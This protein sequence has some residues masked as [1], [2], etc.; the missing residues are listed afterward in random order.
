[1][2]GNFGLRSP[3]LMSVLSGRSLRQN[4]CASTFHWLTLDSVGEASDVWFIL[5][6]S[7]AH[8]MDDRLSATPTESPSKF[9]TAPELLSF[10][11]PV[12]R[13]VQSVGDLLIIPPRWYVFDGQIARDPHRVAVLHRI[14]GKDRLLLFHGHVCQS[15]A[16]VWH[17]IM[18][19]QCTEG[20]IA[21]QH[22][23]LR[24]LT[25]HKVVPSGGVQRSGDDLYHNEVPRIGGQ[26]IALRFPAGIL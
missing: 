9:M 17:Y 20:T 15:T 11:F 19:Y 4:H 25:A 16:W 8:Q 10:P 6:A 22:A 3:R 14:S 1:M 12:F 5:E 2:R 18:S 21:S 7:H 26:R 23:V 13:H 24:T